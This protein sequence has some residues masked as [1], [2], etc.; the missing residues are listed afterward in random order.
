MFLIEP[1][2]DFSMNQRQL[3]TAKL[4][5]PAK[6]SGIP[7]Q[8]LIALL[9]GSLANCTS[10][11]VCARAG[12]GKTTLAHDF[13]QN[14]G[15]PVAWYKLDAPDGDFAVFLEYLT[16]CIRRS[17]PGF[18]IRRLSDILPNEG[19]A[20]PSLTAE[21]LVYELLESASGGPLL[22]V[23]E[24]LHRVCDSAWVIPFFGRLLP[25]LPPDVHILITSRTLPPAPLWRMRSKQTLAVVEDETLNFTRQEAMELFA[26]NG[27]SREQAAIAFDH[28]HGRAAALAGFVTTLQLAERRANRTVK[29]K[30]TFSR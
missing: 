10:T 7:R 14:C 29:M 18:G 27:L 8:R 13:A 2:P 17:R 6:N 26:A 3:I 9:E 11:I 21:A 28:T 16:A 25:L 1:A 5:M 22:I 12:A 24:D 19:E 15:R 30:T 4:E 20:D 23:I